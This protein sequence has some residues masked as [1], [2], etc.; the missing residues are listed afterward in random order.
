LFIPG[1]KDVLNTQVI[2]PKK[3]Y[4]TSAAHQTWSHKKVHQGNGSTYF[5]N[6]FLRTSDAKIKEGAFV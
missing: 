2:N 4:F 5:K 1:Q 3:A 6:K